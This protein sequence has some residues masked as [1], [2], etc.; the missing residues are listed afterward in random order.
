MIKNW[1]LILYFEIRENSLFVDDK[2]ILKKW[3]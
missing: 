3:F 1:K 2:L